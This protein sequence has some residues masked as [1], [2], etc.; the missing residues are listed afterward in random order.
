MLHRNVA[1]VDEQGSIVRWFSSSTEID[2][3]KSAE[4]ALRRTA[5][6]LRRSEFYLA[7]GSA[8]PI[9]GVGPSR[10]MG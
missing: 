8:S 5:D 1:L 2:D 7:E 6:E 10:R 9:S 4:A 3:Q